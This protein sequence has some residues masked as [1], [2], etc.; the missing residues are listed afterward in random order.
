MINNQVSDVHDLRQRLRQAIKKLKALSPDTS[1]EDLSGELRSMGF[2]VGWGDKAGRIL[3]NFKLLRDILEAPAPEPLEKFLSRIPMIFDVV[4]LSP[5]GYF[6]QDQVLGMPDTGGQIVYILNQVTALEK[7]MRHR[8]KQQ[9]LKV[10]PNIIVV[11]RLIPEAEG[12]NCDQ[13]W[14]HIMG[15]HN[16][17]ILRVPFHNAN[18]EVVKHWI[19][20][21]QIYPYLE[22]FTENVEKEILRRLEKKPDLIIGNYTRWQPGGHPA[23]QKTA[24][25]PMQHSPRLGKNQISLFRALLA[26]S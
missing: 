20:R 16:A 11:T 26:G 14:E 17:K 13:E 24:G 4:I 10:E 18:G 23:V 6:G 22:R 19:S 3:K 1:Y 2:E 21:F 7:E 5:H 25:H 8:I 12:T 15:T 9:G